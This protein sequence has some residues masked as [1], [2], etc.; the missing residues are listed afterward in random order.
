MSVAHTWGS[1]P[2][3]RALALPCDR[4]LA[5][6]D[7]TVHR[8]V[9]VDAPP[10]T[11]FRWLCQLRVAPYSWDWIDNFGRRSPR[12]LTPGLERLAVGQP[13]MT[14]FDLVAFERDRHLTLRLRRGRRVV[15][16]V[17]VTYLVVPRAAGG[18]R[19]LVR[20]LW[21]SPSRAAIVRRLGPWLDLVMMRR[22]LLV[23]KR[24]AER[25]A[26]GG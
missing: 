4:H 2:A 8:A 14:I 18:S 6:P 19:L 22:Q 3:E 12:R 7:E 21:R 17:A 1:T 15:G 25:D 10:A 5:E 20:V 11:V 23:L 26:R 24:L 13:I 16:D 9:D